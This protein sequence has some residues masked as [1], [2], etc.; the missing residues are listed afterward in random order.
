MS[1]TRKLDVGKN[2]TVYDAI[3]SR[4]LENSLRPG[5]KLTHQELAEQLGV[6][7]T[8][9]REALERLSQEQYVT[10]LARRGYYVNYIDT[11]EARDLYLMREA[12]ELF[13]L[14]RLFDKGFD[15]EILAPLEAIEQRYKELV[16]QH[17]SRERLLIDREFHLALA[18]LVPNEYL[19]R[20]LEVV[21]DRLIL[22]RRVDGYYDTESVKRHQEHQE[23]LRA[24][25][26]KDRKRAV[27]VLTSHIRGASE[28]L[29]AHLSSLEA[30]D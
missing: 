23:L 2:Q 5:M 18:S 20:Q 13:Q 12:L 1:E 16:T 9:V 27:S 8:P 22:K 26:M 11:T 15:P 28:R 25:R 6:S 30:S 24:L 7:R 17:L 21:F 4:I 19:Y 29:L 3:K 10:R 14:N